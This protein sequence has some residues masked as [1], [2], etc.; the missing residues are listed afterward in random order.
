MFLLAL[1]YCHPSLETPTSVLTYM[2]VTFVH[3]LRLQHLINVDFRME[4]QSS[5]QVVL[6]E[7]SP[8]QEP[9]NL[10]FQRVLRQR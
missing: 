4:E 7:T 5:C 2:P 6:H 1:H 10:A 8:Q 9:G 3:T